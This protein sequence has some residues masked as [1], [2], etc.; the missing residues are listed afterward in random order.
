MA[1]SAGYRQC[2]SPSLAA[3]AVRGEVARLAPTT[4]VADVQPMT[5]FVDQAM[6]PTRFALV[7]IGVFAGIAVVL[8]AVGLYG[9]L[10][11]A[12]RQ[13]TAEIGI[14]MTFGAPP[15]SIFQLVIG[16]GLRL[17]LLGVACGVV[18]ALIVT[19]VMRSL[20]IGVNA[21]V[22]VVVALLGLLVW[23]DAITPW[24]L[25]IFTFLVGAGAALIAPAWQA[26]VPS[27]VPRD[28][29]QAAISLNSVGINISRAIG[30]A[31]AGIVIGIFGLAAPFWLNALSTLGVIG[32][33]WWWRPATS[34]GASRSRTGP[35]WPP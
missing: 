19:R 17:S 33:L 22:A 26:I 20:L 5:A 14:R 7:L 9:V 6:A 8:A 13:R 3:T 16:Q 12:V 23:L 32:V 35:T 1:G 27:L 10:S 28:D 15:T 4:P 2:S 30:P 29:L 21:A 18:A 31:L 34:A 11:T 25:L 24:V